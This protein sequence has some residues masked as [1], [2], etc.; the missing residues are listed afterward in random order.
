MIRQVTYVGSYP[1]YLKLPAYGQPQ[2]AFIGRSNVGKSS[3]INMLMDR[4]ALA[5]VSK[6]P[7]KTQMINLFHVDEQWTLVDLPGYGYAKQSKKKR[8]SWQTMVR[9]YLREAP[10]LYC[11]FILLDGS[12]GP[13]AIDVE[14]ANWMGENQVPFAIVYTKM[15]KVKS[16]KRAQNLNAI[17][18][19]F[20]NHW[21]FLPPEFLVS[22]FSKE[23]Q[24]TLLD[25]IEQLNRSNAQV[26]EP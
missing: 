6:Q 16:S 22:S 8:R 7:G 23:G 25:Y 4:K 21:E 17:R 2:Y 18:Q 24:D 5:R 3:L 11:A 9:N 13:Q 20:L 15:D 19:V 10:E 12:I 26:L 1:S 14:F